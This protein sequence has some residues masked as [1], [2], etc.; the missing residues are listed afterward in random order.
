MVFDSFEGTD[1]IVAI[2]GRTGSYVSNKLDVFEKVFADQR[3]LAELCR[4]IDDGQEPLITH[5]D[6]YLL[7]A[8]AV[9]S[10]SDNI[11]YAV[12]LLPAC[13][14]EKSFSCLDYI[15]IILDQFSLIAGLLGQNQHLGQSS[16]A[17]LASFAGVN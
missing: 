8:K 15:E 9:T 6:S 3:I 5:I 17:E 14:F 4:R 12:I 1:L 7:A 13:T 10:G 2:L 16:R 11:G